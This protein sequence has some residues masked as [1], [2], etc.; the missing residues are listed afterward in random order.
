[1]KSNGIQS[2][3]R[4]TRSRIITQNG[5][6]HWLGIQYGGFFQAEE[7]SLDLGQ[8]KDT[9]FGNIGILFLPELLQVAT[10]PRQISEAFTLPIHHPSTYPGQR[11]DQ[12]EK[13]SVALLL[14]DLC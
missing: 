7:L 1:M 13:G 5:W 3:G 12:G 11:G 8:Q 14:Q 2:Q 4:L 9:A 10:W 6:L